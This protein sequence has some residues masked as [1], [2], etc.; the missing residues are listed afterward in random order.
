MIISCVIKKKKGKTKSHVHQ[1]MK[2]YSLTWHISTVLF[3]NDE[4][5]LIHLEGYM[6][7]WI[8]FLSCT[9]HGHIES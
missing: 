9:Q 4:Q 2:L 6:L 8:S 5:E 3:A 1:T 7:N